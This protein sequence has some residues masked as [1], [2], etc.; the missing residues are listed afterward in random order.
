MTLAA[1]SPPRRLTLLGVD[2]PELKALAA[3]LREQE[4]TD[5]IADKLEPGRLARALLEAQLLLHTTPVGMAPVTEKSI[6]PAEIL[7]AG[8]T[9]FD[10]VYTPRRTQLLRDAVERGCRVVEGLEMFLGQAV[11]QFELWTGKAA[12]RETMRAVIEKRLA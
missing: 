7:H 5:V 2:E 8:L 4:S 9:V 3:T 12:P 11:V 1:E 10:A 6:V